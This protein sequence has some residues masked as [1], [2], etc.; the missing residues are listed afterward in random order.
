MW[1]FLGNK[2]H[3][4]VALL[5]GITKKAFKELLSVSGN[6][7]NKGSAG[8][9]HIHHPAILSIFL[10]TDRIRPSAFKT[11]HSVRP[12]CEFY[13]CHLRA[14]KHNSGQQEA[15][16]KATLFMRNTRCFN[17]LYRQSLHSP[18]STLLSHSDR[19]ILLQIYRGLLA[20]NILRSSQ[21]YCGC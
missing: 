6:Y 2:R 14:V 21:Q 8:L 7:S 3:V 10:F 5:D 18:Y 13:Q 12:F 11:Q 9:I 20:A 4:C 15:E 1:G 16:L 17:R 19:L